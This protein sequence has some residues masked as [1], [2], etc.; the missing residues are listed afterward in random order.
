VNK[1]ISIQLFFC[2]ERQESKVLHA[3]EQLIGIEVECMEIPV[4][5]AVGFAQF[6]QYTEGFQQG[7]LVSWP[8][9]VP[10]VVNEI[11]LVEGLAKHLNTAVLLESIMIPGKWLLAK[12]NCCATDAQ[13]RYLDDGIELELDP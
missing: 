8:S 5:N 2:S 9:S 11:N 12:E 6:T 3:I 13:V 7:V 10:L 4:Q 1:A